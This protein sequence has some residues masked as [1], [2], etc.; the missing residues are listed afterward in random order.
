MK[1]NFKNIKYYGSS[2]NLKKCKS[3][4]LGSLKNNHIIK[5]N[6]NWKNPDK[7]IIEPQNH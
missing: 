1:Y 2:K 3:L 5:S 7:L 4:N 6:E